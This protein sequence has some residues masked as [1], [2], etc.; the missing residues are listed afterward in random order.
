MPVTPVRLSVKNHVA[1]G[2]ALGEVF[3]DRLRDILACEKHPEWERDVK[4]AMAY[5]SDTKKF[6][7]QYAEEIEAYARSSRIRTEDLWTL[8]L[9]LAMDV[10]RCTVMV[11]N[12]GFLVGHVEDFDPSTKDDVVLLER[13]IAGTTVLELFYIYTLGGNSGA[14]NSHGWVHLVNT[15]H[16][17]RTRRGVPRNVIARWFSETKDPKQDARR[18]R[19]IPLSNGYAHTFIDT[20]KGTILSL[21][22]ASHDS[23]MREVHP[24][25]AH[26]NHY[27]FSELTP[28]ESY[29]SSS[30][31]FRLA[32]A[33]VLLK[34]KMTVEAMR[35][36]MA[37]RRRGK[38][39]SIFNQDTIAKVI[40]DLKANEAHTWFARAPKRGFAKT[41]L[42][43]LPK[44]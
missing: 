1:F 8:G 39:D 5:W 32:D 44:R 13:T 25:F 40:F 37:D 38:E 11:A 12:D 35:K 33:E 30:S 41:K 9:E 24:P 4:R 22:T 43:F 14:I 18:L 15:L 42:D 2:E 27:L 17:G 19:N 23:L 31:T 26:T 29:A 6:F 7:P 3:G 16:T 34:P 20:R 36:A 21:E 28:D 10:D